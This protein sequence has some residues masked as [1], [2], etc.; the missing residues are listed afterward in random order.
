MGKNKEGRAGGAQSSFLEAI[1]RKSNTGCMFHFYPG[2][3]Y[4]PCLSGQL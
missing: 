3:I 2:N 4:T 1:I